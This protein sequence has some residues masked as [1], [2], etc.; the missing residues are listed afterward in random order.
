MAD[1]GGRR[2]WRIGDPDR[3]PAQFG[4]WQEGRTFVVGVSDVSD[5][6]S[7][8]PGPLNAEHRFRAASTAVEF[9]LSD[10][11]L[12]LAYELVAHVHAVGP[13]PQLEIDLNGRVGTW[14]LD[15]VRD[16]HVHLMHPTS[17][18]AGWAVVRALLPADAMQAGGLNRLVLTTRELDAPGSD[19][20]LARHPGAS[21]FETGI[22]FG[23]VELRALDE[24][25][26]PG[27]RL[28]PLPFYQ[29]VDN[30]LV[31]LFELVVDDPTADSADI[32]VG[33]HR[34]TVALAPREM[35]QARARVP[36]PA[37]EGQASASVVVGDVVHDF[38]VDPCRKWT[39][40]LLPHV[41]LD[42][43][44]TDYQAK[45]FELHNRNLERAL[46]IGEK[47]A[48]YRFSIDGSFIVERYLATRTPE[49]AAAVLDAV[50]DGRM[51][52]NAF[53]FLFLTGLASLEECYRAGYVAADL[54]DEHG[55]PIDYANLT[56]V[57][58]YSHAVPSAL[59][60]MGIER[61]MGIANHTRASN[62]D[63]DVLHLLSPVRWKGPDGAE[64]LA[65]FADGYSQLRWMLGHPPVLA[66]GVDA[67]GRFIR[68]YERP[69]YL[70][71][72]LPIV[73]I[74]VDNED[75]EAGEASFVD[76]WNERFAFPRIR[77]STMSDYFDAVAPLS[78]RLPVVE[79]DGGSFWEDGVGAGA[80]ITAAYRRAQTALPAAEA[81]AV[82]TMQVD[83]RLGVD[84]EAVD[85]AW[86][87]LLY[88]CEHTWTAAHATIRPN[89][90]STA[91]QLAWKAHQ[92]ATAERAAIDLGR[93]AMSRL[94]ELATTTGNAVVVCNTLSW[95]RPV[96]FDL[97][98]G[99]ELVSAD[100]TRLE[101]VVIGSVDG[102]PVTRY[103]TDAVPA[104]GYRVYEPA[105]R[106]PRE[107]SVDL[108][109]DVVETRRW[110]LELDGSGRVRQLHHDGSPMLDPDHEFRLGDVVYVEGGGTAEGRGYGDERTT[111]WSGDFNLDEPALK[112]TPAD[113]H[114]VGVVRSSW[115]AIVRM[116]GEGPTMRDLRV[117]ITLH[118]DDDRVDI[119]VAFDKAPVLAKESVYVAFPFALS[120][121]TVRYDRQQGWIDPSV[122][123]YPGACTEWFTVQHVVALATDERTVVWSSA[124]APLFTLGDVVRGR[125]GSGCDAADGT[126]LSW[127][128][129]N[130]WFT[131]YP[132]RQEGPVS[133]RYSFTTMPH[134]DAAA[135]GRFGRGVRTAPLV[136]QVTDLDK[137]ER[138]ERVLPASGRSLLDVEADD[139]VVVTVVAQR[140]G[141]G[142]LV[143]VQ[144]L[145]GR[146]GRARIA[147]DGRATRTT[148]TERDIEE[149]AVSDRGVVIEVG[150]HEVA[151]VRLTA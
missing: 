70:P 17:P 33:A 69:D 36:V 108:V 83:D 105:G 89:S 146:T 126:I 20:L 103:R 3:G 18:I 53:Y 10:E 48:D 77:Y 55:L 13:C 25:P 119:S 56:D 133:F 5:F 6:P 28:T 93:E 58:S 15:P 75:L 52:L 91:D 136:S 117:D 81:A 124:D 106:G 27:A 95:A 137:A 131:N 42:I 24:V 101:A 145:A 82:L 129:N 128:M 114:A 41:H 19:E 1:G 66:G 143:R 7:F 125:W 144:E 130:Y 30:G 107:P 139:N 116:A 86:T 34:Q 14:Y 87:A 138:H 141:R 26:V 51:G 71:A 102:V 73:G 44:F 149:L 96:E 127:V 123:H 72:D 8:Q 12:S 111:L 32:T 118:D 40:H 50:R 151:T 23:G 38:T 54:A 47:R 60:A 113:V 90:A 61:F 22:H 63:S 67:L 11:P 94:G 110:R 74:H 68:R 140:R 132:A 76:E 104:F 85:A 46:A 150:P 88:G 109:E 98:C 142:P 79:G 45:V 37:F 100:G 21:G 147:H 29:H 84:R 134:W 122:D 16:H 99:A 112:L 120:A 92:V 31:E 35:G 43:G 9:D 64:V 80:A 39:L 49:A 59:R 65:F 2:V 148:A 57:P 97:E 78:S 135:A 62:D 4:S 121:P 115:G